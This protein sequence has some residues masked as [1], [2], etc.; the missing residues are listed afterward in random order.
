MKPN[1]SFEKRAVANR[2]RYLNTFLILIYP[3]VQGFGRPCKNF[4]VIDT[5]PPA[6]NKPAYY[7]IKANITYK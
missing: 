7:S 4:D 3:Y 6:A 5:L 1:N 2:E